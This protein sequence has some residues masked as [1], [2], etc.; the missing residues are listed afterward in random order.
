MKNGPFFLFV[1]CIICVIAAVFFA[2]KEY[3]ADDFG[4]FI[5]VGSFSF[6]A[7]VSLITG[8]VL[9]RKDEIR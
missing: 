5:I 9:D 4:K 3:P 1:I 7:V 6:F 2:F 8:I